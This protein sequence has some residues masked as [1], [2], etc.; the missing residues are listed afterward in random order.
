VIPPEQRLRAWLPHVLLFVLLVAAA[1]M[2]LV[3]VWPLQEALILAGAIALITYPL[4][5]VPIVVRLG[6]W[7]PGWEDEQRRFAAA[8]ASTALVALALAGTGLLLLWAIFGS[9]EHIANLLSGLVLGNQKRL[10]RA[11]G[12]LAGKIGRILQMYP[13]LPFDAATIKEALQE[14]FARPSVGA[15]VLAWLFKGTGGMVGRA[16]LT[17]VALFYLYA[18]GPALVGLL[19]RHLPLTAAQRD[20]LA[21]RFRGLAMAVLAGSVLR[22]G[23][24]GVW[25]GLAAWAVAGANPLI[26]GGV[27]GF[28]A[29]LP[30]V[31]PA[32]AW[33]PLASLAWTSGNRAEAICLAVGCTAGAWVIELLFRRWSRHLGAADLW[34]A[35]LLFLGLIGGVAAFG[36]RGLVIG[37][38]AALTAAALFGFVPAVYG[39]ARDDAPR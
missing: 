37:P 22:A 20:D 38:A 33:L 8:A 35:F 27:A 1:G 30:V 12:Q 21:Q 25:C 39:M 26:A 4:V 16:A 2:L 13:Q 28:L 34:F 6:R 31:G 32:I 18:Q 29:L 36:L 15:D 10:D 3:V 7:F 11:L 9:F 24:H 19:T 14:A 5:Y 23:A 17:L